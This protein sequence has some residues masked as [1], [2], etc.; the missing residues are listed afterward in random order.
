MPS[1]SKAPALLLVLVVTS[2]IITLTTLTT[3]V[4]ASSATTVGGRNDLD[5][6]RKIKNSKKTNTKKGATC[7][8]QDFL[9]TSQYS[10]CK[11]EETEVEIACDTTDNAAT[12]TTKKICTY[13]EH[14]VQYD[15]AAAAA[16]AV[17]CGDHGTFDPQVHLT[18]DHTTGVCRLDFIA[19]TNSCDAALPGA[20]GS[21]FGVMVE[22]PLS[23][24]PGSLNHHEHHE[25]TNHTKNSGMLLRFSFDAGATFYNNK[26]PSRTVSLDRSSSRR[27]LDGPAPRDCSPSEG[28]FGG[29]SKVLPWLAQPKAF[30]TCFSKNPDKDLG[31]GMCWTQSWCCKTGCFPCVPNGYERNNDVIMIKRNNEPCGEACQEQHDCSGN[32]ACDAVILIY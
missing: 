28:T 16:T 17:S 9:G 20:G 25:D 7:T 23:T 4:A 12:T 21:T 1:F 2:S 29:V 5:L 11:R 22:A 3:V 18:R 19:L 32:S 31:T 30:E 10:N 13:S 6:V 14:P 8:M 24:G 27:K 26:D 15:D